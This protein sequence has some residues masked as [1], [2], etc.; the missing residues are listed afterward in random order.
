MAAFGQSTQSVECLGQH[1]PYSPAE[2]KPSMRIARCDLELQ[3]A[4]D[5]YGQGDQGVR[6]DCRADQYHKLRPVEEAQDDL[7]KTAVVLF[8]HKRMSSVGQENVLLVPRLK[9]REEGQ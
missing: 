7:L 1:T 9:L 6:I 5:R 3:I 8:E 4:S 2:A